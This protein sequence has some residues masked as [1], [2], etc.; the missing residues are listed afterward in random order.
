MTFHIPSRAELIEVLRN[1][2]INSP[3]FEANPTD[4]IGECKYHDL[5]ANIKAGCFPLKSFVSAYTELD[6]SGEDFSY[7]KIKLLA[8]QTFHRAKF[9]S[10][11]AHTRAWEDGLMV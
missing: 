5:C 9:A 4:V 2:A 3:F 7:G 6:A 1:A 11:D 10:L 8:M